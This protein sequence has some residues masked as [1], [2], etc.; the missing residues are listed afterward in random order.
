MW[1]SILALAWILM[2]SDV[3]AEESRVTVR[4]LSPGLQLTGWQA[5]WTVKG[6][7]LQ[8]VF[9]LPGGRILAIVKA[10]NDGPRELVLWSKDGH[11][12]VRATLDLS[13]EIRDWWQSSSKLLLASKDE[14]VEYDLSSLRP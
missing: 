9:P 7:I 12:L 14:F 13:G 6:E 11:E 8:P 2:A 10:P 5:S 1:H 4:A 3:H